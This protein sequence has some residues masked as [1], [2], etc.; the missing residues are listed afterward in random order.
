ME[1]QVWGEGGGAS[2]PLSVPRET[3]AS[4]GPGAARSS[5]NRAGPLIAGASERGPRR[6]A[7]AGERAAK[8]LQAAILVGFSARTFTF[9]GAQ[10][11]ICQKWG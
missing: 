8:A 5:K 11:M 4:G 9:G 10:R 1:E 7:A 2:C 6:I 3:Q